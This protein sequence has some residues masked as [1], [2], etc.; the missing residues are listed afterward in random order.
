[1]VASNPPAEPPMPTMGQL[2]FF[3]RT[4][5]RNCCATGLDCADFVRFGFAR[6]R[7]ARF[8]V[9]FAA[10]ASPILLPAFF[11][12]KLRLKQNSRRAAVSTI[13]RRR[14]SMGPRATL[15]PLFRTIAA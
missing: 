3:F 15:G 9:G 13:R 8:D 14:I 7:D 4:F 10:M 12:Y 5:G 2:K 6:E 1:M 11:S